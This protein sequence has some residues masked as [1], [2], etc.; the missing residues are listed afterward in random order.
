MKHN[1]GSTDRLVRFIIAAI[2]VGV[3]VLTRNWI[4]G[5]IALYPLATAIFQYCPAKNAFQFDSR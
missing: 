4:F 3:T 2:L 5:V 1:M